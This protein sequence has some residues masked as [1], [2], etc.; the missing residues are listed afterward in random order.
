MR[1]SNIHLFPR[2]LHSYSHC[3]VHFKCLASPWRLH[4]PPHQLSLP[5]HHCDRSS[6]CSH[7][8]LL[9]M[10]HP[11]QAMRELLPSVR[12]TTYLRDHSCCRLLG[13]PG[14]SHRDRV[15]NTKGLLARK[16]NRKKLGRMGSPSAQW[17]AGALEQRL[18]FREVPPL[19]EKER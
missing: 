15:R 3:P 10:F 8:V 19:A 12:L 1:L 6:S 7:A 11:S 14:G 18:L 5:G 9:S 16:G 17:G 13:S 2:S 4:Y